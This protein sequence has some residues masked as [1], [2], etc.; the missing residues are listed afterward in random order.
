MLKIHAHYVRTQC[1]RIGVIS[2]NNKALSSRN[3]KDIILLSGPSVLVRVYTSTIET[4]L[5][6]SVAKIGRPNFDCVLGKVTLTKDLF[7]QLFLKHDRREDVMRFGVCVCV[8][9]KKRICFLFLSYIT[10]YLLH[11]AVFVLLL[12]M[13]LHFVLDFST[14]LS[15][16]L[17]TV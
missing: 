3:N 14:P 9:K 2:N 4:R 5:V 16:C 1:I 7:A 6:L 8:F 12:P 10:R 15:E 13:K 17:S 11:H